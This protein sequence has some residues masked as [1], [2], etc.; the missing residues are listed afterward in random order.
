MKLFRSIGLLVLL[1]VA[2]SLQSQESLLKPY[3]PNANKHIHKSEKHFKTLHQL[4]FGGSNAEAYFSYD[5]NRLIFQAKNPHW[6]V[7]CDQIFLMD[8][9]E[10]YSNEKPA[11]RISTGLGRTTCSYFLPGDSLIIYSSTHL[12][13]HACPPVP[14]RRYGGRYVWPIYRTF[15]IFVADLQGNVV[16]QLTN[17]KGYDAEATVSPK[18]DKIVFTSYRQETGDLN[19][20]TMNIDGSKLKQITTQ[21]GYQGGAFFSPDGSRICFRGSAF[22]TDEEIAEY[23]ELLGI[24]QVEPIKMEIF[25]VGADGQD[26]K[27]VTKLG[28]ANWAPYY[29]PSGNK[30]IFSSNH[31]TERGHPFKLFMINTDGTGLEQITFGDS[32]ESFP[33]FSHCGRYLVFSSSRNNEKGTR[34]INVFIAEWMD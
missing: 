18:G 29:H 14:E 16:S 2:N 5:N 22:T 1:L 4:S 9:S 12:G 17:N 10:T 3:E 27:Q 13:D 25:T 31:H 23:R 8:L 28:G 7:E 21:E 33:M 34:D 19:L 26:L 30:I 20:Y 6:D 11:P 15:D 24:D 32:F